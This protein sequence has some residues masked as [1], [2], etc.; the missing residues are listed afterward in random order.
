MQLPV[1]DGSY[2]CVRFLA[3]YSR[4]SV[5]QELLLGRD[6]ISVRV[7]AQAAIETLPQGEDGRPLERPEMRRT[8]AAA[9]GRG[10]S[11]GC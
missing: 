3:E 4:Y 1:G 10:S 11:C 2:Y 5:H 9:S 6:G 7:A 8:T